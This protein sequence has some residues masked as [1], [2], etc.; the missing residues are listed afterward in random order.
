[1]PRQ[2]FVLFA[3]LMLT[4]V[5]VASAHEHGMARTSSQ[6]TETT[7]LVAAMPATTQALDHAVV[8]LAASSASL[9]SDARDACRNHSKFTDCACP[10]ACSGVFSV[11]AT[12]TLLLAEVSAAAPSSG[13][14]LLA[15]SS[16]P[17][18]PP[19]RA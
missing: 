19:P 17:P 10:A 1:M 15:T 18:T 7:A 13:Q 9:C 12:T 14:R 6:L 3:L 8:W 2:V 16:A 4:F 5:S 11:A